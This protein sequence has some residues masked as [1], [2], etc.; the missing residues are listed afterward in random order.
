[1]P[2][3]ADAG[4]A[5]TGGDRSDPLATL[6]ASSPAVPPAPTAFAGAWWSRLDAV[7][8]RVG[9]PAPAT[10]LLAGALL[11]AVVVVAIVAS[12]VWWVGR[13]GPPGAEVPAPVDRD[14]ALPLATT[15]TAARPV[16]VHAAGAVARPGVYEL[17]T[18]SR[19]VD[20]L[21]AAGG[22]A[23]DADASR[24]NLAEPLAD[25]GRLYVPR[26]GEA[27]PPTVVTGGGGAGAGP[28]PGGR[29]VRPAATRPARST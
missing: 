15:T 25:G 9:I 12:T 21:E 5:A 14:A 26:V 28:R 19:V 27:E 22:P 24:L 29:R 10:V 8:A 7:A 6:R 20:L 17:P 11:A 18:G 16:V 13:E 3:H 1:M 2:D 4:T 23:A